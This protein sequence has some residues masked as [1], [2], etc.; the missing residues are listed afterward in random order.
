MRLRALGP[1]C[2]DRSPS[3]TSC[4]LM[5]RA[6]LSFLS[7][8]VLWLNP[9][10]VSC[11][12]MSSKQRTYKQTIRPAQIFGLGRQHRGIRNTDAKSTH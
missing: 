10:A 6:K 8:L 12:V 11:F 7:R 3:V 1:Y 4:H 9:F 5:V 2:T